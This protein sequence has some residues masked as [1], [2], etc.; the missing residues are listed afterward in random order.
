[1]TH[2]NKNYKLFFLNENFEK[3]GGISGGLFAHAHNFTNIK[4][5]LQ[6]NT[7]RKHKRNGHFGSKSAATID[8]L[9]FMQKDK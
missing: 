4:G 5:Y 3:V 8:F 1:M 2:N 6:D 7:I 9:F